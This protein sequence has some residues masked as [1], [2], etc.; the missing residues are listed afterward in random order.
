ME[1]VTVTPAVLWSS[2]ALSFVTAV[3]FGIAPALP[4]SKPDRAPVSRKQAFRLD[5]Q[6]AVAAARHT[7]A[8]EVALSVMVAAIS[9]QRPAITDARSRI[10][11]GTGFDLPR[12]PQVEVAA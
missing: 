12:D 2:V 11:S 10:R 5:G 4:G 8:G 3:L 9:A 1:T 7:V 6:E